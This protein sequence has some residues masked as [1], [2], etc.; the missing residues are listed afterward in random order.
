MEISLKRIATYS[1]TNPC[2][3]NDYSLIILNRSKCCLKIGVFG[4]S[5]NIQRFVFKQHQSSTHTHI[6]LNVH[7]HTHSH[8]YIP[9]RIHILTCK[10]THAR[11][12]Q[13]TS[14]KYLLSEPLPGSRSFLK[15]HKSYKCLQHL[16][17]TGQTSH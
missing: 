2:K 7:T 16:N 14:R 1:F 12:C 8:G 5:K 13:A 15:A 4:Q 6:H 11:T 3:R 9:K 17:R 10:H